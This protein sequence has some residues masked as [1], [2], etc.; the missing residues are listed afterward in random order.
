SAA[1][2]AVRTRA[3]SSA[4]SRA[5]S[6]ISTGRST[7]RSPAERDM[8]AQTQPVSALSPFRFPVFR[9]VWSASTI[10]N[11]GGIIQSVGAAWMM[12]SIARSADMVALVQASVT[13][14]IMLLALFAG[15]IA[16][17]LDRRK[18]MLGAQIVMFVVSIGLS[19][20]AWMGL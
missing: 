8:S 2:R 18:V 1:S 15:A 10:S 9:A 17:N 12:T 13:L 11:L 16:D 14:P 5:R 19:L 6:F 4:D 7:R 3:S 20:C